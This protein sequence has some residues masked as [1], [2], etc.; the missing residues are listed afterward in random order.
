MANRK[1]KRP[2]QPQECAICCALCAVIV[3]PALVEGGVNCEGYGA[4]LEENFY[5]FLPGLGNDLNE[6]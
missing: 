4:L 1:S 3:G 5:F 6:M 2:L